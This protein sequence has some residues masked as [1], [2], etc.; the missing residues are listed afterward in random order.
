VAPGK[1]APLKP[2]DVK[3]GR[4]ARVSKMLMSMFKV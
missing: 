1:G 2:T 3:P 4:C